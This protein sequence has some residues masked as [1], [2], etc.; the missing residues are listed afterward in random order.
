MNTPQLSYSTFHRQ[1]LRFKKAIYLEFGE[2]FDSFHTGEPLKQEGYKVEISRQGRRIL[3]FENWN[4]D[5]IGTGKILRHV[6]AAIEINNPTLDIRNNLVQWEN[7]RGEEGR[8]HQSLYTALED[9]AQTAAY[10]KTLFELYHEQIPHA[11]A[12]ERIV[13]HAGR[14]YAYVAYL[15][16]LLDP[17]RYLPIATRNFDRAFEM[18]DAPLKTSQKCSWENYT[19]YLAVME[20]VRT[21]LIGEGVENVS[22]LDAHSFCWMLATLPLPEDREPSVRPTFEHFECASL[23]NNAK[24]SGDL[25][26]FEESGR[27]RGYLRGLAEEI[28]LEFER[29]RLRDAGCIDLA[30]RVRLVSDDHRRGYDIASF[31]TDGTPRY[32]EVKAVRK[33]SEGVRFYVTENEFEKCQTLAP[34]FFYFVSGVLDEPEIRYLRSEELPEDALQP[35]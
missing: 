29:E 6:I 26:D 10:E 13:D 21:A 28:V 30:K 12:F 16:F 15:F 4:E 34:Y 19:A 18:L 3:E 8:P 14:Q 27:K 24:S 23:Q 20:Q 22:L 7:R 5:N 31:E 25:I 11:E 17:D 9:P 32:V 1:Y 33:N 2:H 35:V